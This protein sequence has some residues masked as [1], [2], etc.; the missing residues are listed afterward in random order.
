MPEYQLATSCGTPSR[1]LLQ[2]THAVL[3]GTVATI[4]YCNVPLIV[5]QGQIFEQKFI[6]NWF[7]IVHFLYSI[8][9]I[10]LEYL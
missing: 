8:V 4:G 9:T 1:Y 10:V 6:G 5:D 2:T 3:E 7:H